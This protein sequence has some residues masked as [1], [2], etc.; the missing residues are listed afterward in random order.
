M[1]IT[2]TTTTTT[3]S[4]YHVALATAWARYNSLSGRATA[5]QVARILGH[6]TIDELARM[7][8]ARGITVTV[9]Q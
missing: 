4:P 3:H 2:T 1:P 6:C 7:L 9:A 5:K 8:A